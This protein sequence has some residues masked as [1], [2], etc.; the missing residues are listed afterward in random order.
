MIVIGRIVSVKEAQHG[1]CRNLPSA[2]IFLSAVGLHRA[3]VIIKSKGGV[4]ASVGEGFTAESFHQLVIVQIVRS[5]IE[6]FAFL[7]ISGQ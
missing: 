2:F 4:A 6:C 1:I 3:P 5:G 7:I